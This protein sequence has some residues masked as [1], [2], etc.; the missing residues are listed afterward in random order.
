MAETAIE[1]TTGVDTTTETVVGT[2][3]TTE[4]SV[5]IGMVATSIEIGVAAET[6]ARTLIVMEGA[7]A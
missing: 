7:A 3:I 5:R 1:V 2:D 4:A 6:E